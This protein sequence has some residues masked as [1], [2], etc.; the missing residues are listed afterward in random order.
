[1]CV[2]VVSNNRRK[3]RWEW[4][5]NIVNDCSYIDGDHCIFSCEAMHVQKG[6]WT[7]CSVDFAGGYLSI[8][9]KAGCPDRNVQEPRLRG[10][11]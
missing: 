6:T 2:L 11:A 9:L 3:G 5:D 7:A 8:F 10:F 1:M 4:P